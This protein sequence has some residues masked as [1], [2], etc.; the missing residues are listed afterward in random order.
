MFKTI[1]LPSSQFQA[2]SFKVSGGG[3]GPEWTIDSVDGQTLTE[4][5]DLINT[6]GPSGFYGA[7][8]NYSVT[9]TGQP[10]ERVQATINKALLD[11]SS[12]RGLDFIEPFYG[13]IR[14]TVYGDSDL[15]T[16][17]FSTEPV[18]LVVTS[19]FSESMTIQFTSGAAPRSDG[20]FEI[21]VEFI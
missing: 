9:F 7:N 13:Y 5:G 14:S 2:R 19:N 20:M 6:N 10:G 16:G 1:T 8:E 4:A 11:G 3:G 12:L 18:P 15:N 21:N 17:T